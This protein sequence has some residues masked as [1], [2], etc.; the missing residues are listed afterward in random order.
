[1]SSDTEDISV[2]CSSLSFVYSVFYNSPHF[3]QV[4][5][6]L[7]HF[8]LLHFV[9]SSFC[10]LL[11]HFV[12]C[13]F[14]ICTKELSRDSAVLGFVVHAILPVPDFVPLTVGLPF[15]IAGLK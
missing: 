1:M 14:C 10:T 2:F 9:T 15:E 13:T 11:M 6:V 8:V 5:F 12:P 4:R 7:L 3:V